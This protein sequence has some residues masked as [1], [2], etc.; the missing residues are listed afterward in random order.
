M[1]SRRVS[2]R[3][4]VRGAFWSVPGALL[5]AACSQA[6]STAAPATAAPAQQTGGAVATAQPAAGRAAAPL[7]VWFHWGGK[8]GDG[9]Q[10]LVES[11]NQ[12]QGGQ[13][14]A[15]ATIET[16]SSNPDEYRPKMTAARAAGTA[17]DVY[18]MGFAIR[19]VVKAEVPA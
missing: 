8:M 12:T 15:S 10:K 5:L 4:V 18:N 19:E 16:V 2:R 6:P 3:V 14:K 9:I 1:S 7:R 17:P 11:Y 13:D